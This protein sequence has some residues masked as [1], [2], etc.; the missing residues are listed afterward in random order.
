MAL[1]ANA[2]VE[3]QGGIA[4]VQG[5]RVEAQL[6]LPVAGLLS[7]DSGQEVARQVAAVRAAMEKM[8]YHH[9]NPFMSLATLS[10]PV[11]PA[12]KLSDK[13]LINVAE[14]RFTGHLCGLD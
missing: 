11:S 5:E 8:G 7:L 1:A 10:L 9:A 2:V 3:A 14:R 6:K 12:L 13:G 4:I